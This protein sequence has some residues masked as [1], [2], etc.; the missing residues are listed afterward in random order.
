MEAARAERADVDVPF[1]VLDPGEA[2]PLA[3][4]RLADID[5]AGVP[6]DAAVVAPTAHLVVRRVFTALSVR[7]VRSCRPL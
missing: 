2:D 7:C 1:T 4:E 6:A 3:P 5:P